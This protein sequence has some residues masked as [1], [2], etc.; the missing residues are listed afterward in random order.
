MQNSTTSFRCRVLRLAV[1]FPNT[2]KGITIASLVAQRK[3]KAVRDSLYT[4]TPQG[5]P[6][7]AAT[8][9]RHDNQFKCRYVRE[10][11]RVPGEYKFDKR[12]SASVTR[13]ENGGFAVDGK[14]HKRY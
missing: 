5:C 13:D 2:T 1:Y 6:G 9:V 14:F 7:V 10:V 8:F 4:K 12:W 3:R 11:D